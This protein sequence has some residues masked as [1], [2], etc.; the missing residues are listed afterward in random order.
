M[1]D[2]IGLSDAPRPDMVAC[3]RALAIVLHALEE[4]PFAVLEHV[5]RA[6][7]GPRDLH[8]AHRWYGSRLAELSRKFLG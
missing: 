7:E 8:A 3:G 1:A 6:G 2:L 5:A 4:V